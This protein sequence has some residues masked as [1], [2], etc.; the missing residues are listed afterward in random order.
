MNTSDCM[1]TVRFRP[2]R[3]GM[4]PTFTLKLYYL[5]VGYRLIMKGKTVEILFEGEDFGCSPLHGIDSDDCV[6]SLMNFLTLRPGDTDAEY[7][8]NYTQVQKDY[9]DEHAEALSAEV[10]NRFGE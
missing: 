3:K 9:C 2:Y 1:R 7:F 6:K 8:A 5:P 4:G 10:Y